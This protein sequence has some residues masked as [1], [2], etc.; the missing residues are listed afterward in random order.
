M[1]F[2]AID[3]E[4]ANFARASAC[5]VGLVRVE[6]GAL[7]DRSEWFIDP[8]GGAYFTNTFIHGITER[9]VE[10]APTWGESVERISAFSA[11]LPLIAYSGFDRGVYNAANAVLGLP[12]RG[13]SWLNAY[14]LVRR[15][16]PPGSVAVDDYRLPTIVN[17]LGVADFEHHKAVEDAAA[18]AGIVLKVAA[19]DG[20]G[21]LD[22][23]WPARVYGPRHR[24]YAPKAPLPDPNPDADPAHPLY[25]QRVCFTGKLDSFTQGEAERIAADFGCEVEDNM[26]RHTTLVVV[27]QFDPAHLRAGAALSNKAK[28]AAELAV[29]GQRIEVTDETGFLAYINL[30]PSDY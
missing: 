27:G 3:F 29:K 28:R 19:M 2:V 26:T 6:G 12:D 20:L 4:T 10:G 18:C 11:G 25:G 30:D 14:S 16:F 9:D 7:A 13:F 1:D 22:E 8:P 15:R 23:L 24:I 21:D 5:A 17:F